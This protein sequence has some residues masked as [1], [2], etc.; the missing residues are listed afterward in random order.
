MGI[1]LIPAEEQVSARIPYKT[2]IQEAKSET[3]KKA[4]AVRRGGREI[5]QGFI[6]DIPFNFSFESITT[7]FNLSI[8]VNTYFDIFPS[9]V[10]SPRGVRREKVREVHRGV[11]KLNLYIIIALCGVRQESGKMLLF[12]ANLWVFSCKLL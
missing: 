9:T 3:M 6:C 11:G 5:D 4:L 8:L 10:I 12:L 1:L 7:N 2:T